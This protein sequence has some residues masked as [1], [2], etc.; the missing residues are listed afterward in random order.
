VFKGGIGVTTKAG[1]GDTEQH[2]LCSATGFSQ[3]GGHASEYAVGHAG[4]QLTVN[5]YG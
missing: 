1:T 2:I 5:A 4:D 3:R